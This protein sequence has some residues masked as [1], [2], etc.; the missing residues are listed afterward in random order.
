MAKP[1]DLSQKKA[2]FTGGTALDL[3]AV[4]ETTAKA[5][6]IGS[7]TLVNRLKSINLLRGEETFSVTKSQ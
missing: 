7:E 4:P 1:S 2:H 6:P 5:R 3:W